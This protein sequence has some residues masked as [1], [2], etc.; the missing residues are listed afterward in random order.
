[1]SELVFTVD[2]EPVAKARA[3]KGKRS[4]FTPGETVAFER[5]VAL[6]SEIARRA[7]KLPLLTKA[8]ELRVDCFFTAKKGATHTHP[9]YKDTRPDW[10]NL[11]KIVSD[12]LNTCVWS[13]DGRVADGRCVT[14]WQVPGRRPCTIVRVCSL[15]GEWDS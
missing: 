12:A 14:W 8:V 2:G 4:M 9:I 7:A 3:R 11:G 6:A 5:R 15:A 10:D 13:D 1:M